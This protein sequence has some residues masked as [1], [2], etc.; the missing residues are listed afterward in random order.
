MGLG[1]L[2]AKARMKTY[3]A[4]MVSNRDSQERVQ[5]NVQVVATACTLLTLSWCV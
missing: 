5:L 1:D 4:C 2:S 3:E